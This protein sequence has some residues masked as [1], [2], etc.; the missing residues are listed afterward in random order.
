MFNKFRNQSNYHKV[1]EEEGI[2]TGISFLDEEGNPLPSE[3]VPDGVLTLK[4]IIERHRRGQ[5]VPVN[6]QKFEEEIAEYTGNFPDTTKMSKIELTELAHNLSDFIKSSRNAI[7]EY[8][9]K[10]ASKLEQDPT[11]EKDKLEE[12]KPKE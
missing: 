9:E 6:D 4:Q 3:T 8:N 1:N 10:A 5:Y 12:S 11:P 2:V 7:K